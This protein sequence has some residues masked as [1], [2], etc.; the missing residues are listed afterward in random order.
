VRGAQRYQ[1]LNQVA[2]DETTAPV[3]QNTFVFPV[4][5]LANPPFGSMSW[6]QFL[7]ESKAA[8]GYIYP[9]LM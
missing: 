9:G 2:T 4:Q 8:G 6:S 5:K 3:N 7:R 1:T